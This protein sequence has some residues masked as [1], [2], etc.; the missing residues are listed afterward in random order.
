MDLYEEYRKWQPTYA[1]YMAMSKHNRQ[2]Y[3]VIGLA[4][5]AGEVLSLAQKAKRNYR[6]IDRDKLIDELGDVLWYFTGICNEFDIDTD[7][8]IKFNMEKLKERNNGNK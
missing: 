7:D 2:E 4:A 8:I 6:Y 5:E 1:K 3:T